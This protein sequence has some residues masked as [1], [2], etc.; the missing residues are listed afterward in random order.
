MMHKIKDLDNR[1]N[2][3]RHCTLVIRMQIT[4]ITMFSNIQTLLLAGFGDSGV[5]IVALSVEHNRT[6]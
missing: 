4:K 5:L 6:I 2:N 1:N 3:Y